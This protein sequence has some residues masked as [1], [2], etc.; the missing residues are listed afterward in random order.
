MRWHAPE[1]L[2][3]TY[4]QSYSSKLTGESQSWSLGVLLWEIA[5][6]GATPYSQYQTTHEFVE[7]ITAAT[8]SFPPERLSHVDNELWLAR[9]DCTLSVFLFTGRCYRNVGSLRRMIE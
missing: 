6:F 2:N 8:H 5:S 4:G 9:I 7:A 3:T 1:V